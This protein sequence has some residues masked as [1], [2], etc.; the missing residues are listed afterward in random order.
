MGKLDKVFLRMSLM[1]AL[2]GGY[3]LV[4]YIFSKP[5]EGAGEGGIEAASFILLAWLLCFVAY[6]RKGRSDGS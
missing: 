2:I 1:A 3:Q 4:R 6:W 5:A